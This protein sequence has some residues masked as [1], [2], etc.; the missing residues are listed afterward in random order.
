MCLHGF[1]SHFNFIRGRTPLH[2]AVVHSQRII[3]RALIDD[4]KADP[5]L[6]DFSGY[7]PYML[8]EDNLKAEYE[9]TYG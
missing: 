9:R 4:F 6:M 8:L 7:F 1:T 5:S 3:I 2:I